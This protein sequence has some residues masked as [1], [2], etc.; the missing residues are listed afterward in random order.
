MTDQS[1]QSMKPRWI[2]SGFILLI[3]VL[4]GLVYL[5]HFGSHATATDQQAGMPP[6]PVAEVLTLHKRPVRAWT[7]FSGRL[8]PVEWAEIKPLVSGEL[9]QVLFEDGQLVA[10][11]DLLFV[12]DPRPF[13][14]TV[15]RAGAQLESARSRARLAKDELQRASA[16]LE[17]KLIAQS[18]FDSARNASQVADAEIQEVKT[19]LERA[20]LDLAY[21]YIRAP[22]AG[23]V[24]RAELTVGNIVETTPNAPVLT[25][26]VSTDRLYAEFNVDEQT[27]IKSVRS[28]SGTGQHMPVEMTLAA[29]P[30]R[31]Y[32]GEIDSFDNQL[33][34][35]SGTIR[36]RAIFDNTDGV[37]T[38]GMYANVRLG[39][40]TMS[41]ALL[42]P[43]R[44]IG[45]NQ[46]KK[47]VYLVDSENRAQYREIKLGEQFGS[48]R[49]VL[50]G[51]SDG[52]RVV[53]NGL[54]HVR[55]NTP[56]TV[57]QID[58]D[59]RQPDAGN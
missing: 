44:A 43:T 10:K 28:G 19:A 36:A 40:A 27:Y 39:A 15:K 12:I 9:Q 47:F 3:P 24:S 58:P 22:F 33:D 13:K 52:D 21:C 31:T 18:T 54:S 41:E 34:S 6:P 42:V 53:V 2:K 5:N 51:V 7:D 55:P 4:A 14:A 11:E 23:R 25:T 17:R 46:D 45:T 56:L 20:R 49:A 29:D 30:S 16:L 35:N 57:K 1:K 8:T 38:P 32:Q 26:I 37:L 59:S 50:A 48:A